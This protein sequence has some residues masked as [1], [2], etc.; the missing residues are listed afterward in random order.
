MRQ[1]VEITGLSPKIDT[2]TLQMLPGV[3]MQ[4]RKADGKI[5]HFDLAASHLEVMNMLHVQNFSEAIGKKYDMETDD[6]GKL[7]SMS[8]ADTRVITY[9]EFEK[10][11]KN[12]SQIL[13]MLSKK[14]N[15]LNTAN[16]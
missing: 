6:K 12:V 9:G 5:E 7:I 14:S 2:T 4:F 10:L 16:P 11:Q 13:E 1:I 8:L 15:V 3:S